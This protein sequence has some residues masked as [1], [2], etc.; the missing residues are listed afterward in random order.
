[1]SKKKIRPIGKILL[2]LEVLLDEMCDQGLQ[3]GD[4]LSLVHSQIQV[5]RQDAIEVY[6]DDG[7]SPIMYYGPKE[8]K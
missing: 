2:D 7:T 6:D 4:I 1:M 5:H 8:N 3:L